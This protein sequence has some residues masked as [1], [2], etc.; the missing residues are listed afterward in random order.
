MIHEREPDLTACFLNRMPVDCMSSPA[1]SSHE[2]V[3]HVK[4]NKQLVAFAGTESLI[5]AD[6]VTLFGHKLVRGEWLSSVS[7]LTCA[8][9]LTRIYGTFVKLVSVYGEEGQRKTCHPSGAPNGQIL[10]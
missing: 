2:V 9:T 4:G 5:L 10:L 1:V 3:Q 7:C 8:R 6:V